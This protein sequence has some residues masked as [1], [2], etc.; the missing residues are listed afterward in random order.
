MSGFPFAR[1][2]RAIRAL[3]RGACGAALAFVSLTAQAADGYRLGPQDKVRIKIVEWRPGNG[4]AIEWKPLSDIYTV[5]PSGNLAVPMLGEIS[6]ANRTTSEVAEAIGIEMQKR[7]GLASRPEVSVEVDTYRPF[8]VLG[9]VEKPGSYPY[10]PGMTPLQAVGIAGGF[11]RPSD[12]GLLRIE[13]DRIT[14]LGLLEENRIALL[15][16]LVREARLEGELQDKVEIRLPPDLEKRDVRSVVADEEAVAKS[17]AQDFAARISAAAGLKT[18]L[19]DQI[20]T[21]SAKIDAQNQQVDISKRELQSY[22]TLRSQGLTVTSRS[23]ALERAVSEAEGRRIDYE[24]ALLTARQDSRKA[25]QSQI[26]LRNERM[27]EIFRD[28]AGTRTAIA[29]ARAKIAA[30]DGLLQEATVTAPALVLDR[31]RSQERQP[32]YLLTRR[33]SGRDQVSVTVVTEST[34]LEPDDVLRVELPSRPGRAD[35]GISGE[36]APARRAAGR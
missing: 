12:A 23:F 9:V 27:S 26:D 1:R 16:S 36:I 34:T 5:N 17:R 8:Y 31:E 18:L 24:I 15:R 29:Q 32:I 7:V 4:E 11:Y 22:S 21:L 10:R 20:R 6:S 13:R 35:P 3:L 25:E 2:K 33:Q 14:A 28:L 19:D 30:Q